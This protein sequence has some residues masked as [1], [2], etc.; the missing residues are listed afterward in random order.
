MYTFEDGKLTD[1]DSIGFKTREVQRLRLLTEE[2]VQTALTLV[3]KKALVFVEYD[4]TLHNV[5]ARLTTAAGE[6]TII[7]H[8]S[9]DLTVEPV[10]ED[11]PDITDRLPTLSQFVS[12]RMDESEDDKRLSALCCAI[13][14]PK[15]DHRS[16]IDQFVETRMDG[17]I[18]A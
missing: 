1:I 9:L 4:R 7:Q 15:T 16:V 5:I 13:T 17:K 18:I 2:D 8:R 10:T 14:D 3:S 12:A 6:D 11:T